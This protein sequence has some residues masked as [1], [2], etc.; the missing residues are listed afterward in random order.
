[1]TPTGF[2]LGQII[3]VFAVAVGGLWFATEWAAWH[4]GYQPRLGL[5]WF[6]LFSWPDRLPLQVQVLLVETFE[7]TGRVP[8]VSR[9]NTALGA[10]LTRIVSWTLDTAPPLPRT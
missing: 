3:V 8:A 9:D 6:V 5:P 7:R 4:L 10:A 2:L 1:M